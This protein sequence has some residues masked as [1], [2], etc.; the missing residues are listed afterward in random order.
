M[1]QDV[2]HAELREKTQQLLQGALKHV[3]AAALAA[4]LVPLG[5]VAVSPAVAQDRCCGG[6]PPAVPSPCDFVT[7]GGFVVTDSNVMANFGVHGGC[8]KGNFWGHVNYVDHGTG[9]HVDSIQITG[10]VDP[11]PPSNTRDICG[12]ATTNVS[13]P[14]VRFRVRLIDNGEPGTNDGFGIRLSNAYHVATRLLG[15]GGPG[16]GN[17]DLHDPNPSTVGPDPAPDE[18]TMCGLV[19][20]P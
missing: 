12:V 14:P 9:Y 11:S 15:G 20:A 6:C 2:R 1:S 13:E 4:A 5:A 16:G 8:K 3:R 10:Y 19:G 18:F 7:S 17:I